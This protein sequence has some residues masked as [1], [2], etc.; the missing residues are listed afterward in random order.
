VP[1]RS[2]STKSNNEDAAARQA[3]R[4]KLWGDM[5]ILLAGVAAVVAIVWIISGHSVG[6]AGE[7]IWPMNITPGGQYVPFV[8]AAALLIAVAGWL[9]RPGRWEKTRRKVRVIWLIIIILISGLLAD[10]LLLMRSN[11]LLVVSGIITSREATSYFPA[12]IAIP[13]LPEALRDYPALMHKLPQH[14]RTHP[15]GPIVF[16]WVVDRWVQSSPALQH[17][18]AV[19][20]KRIDPLLTDDLPNILGRELGI[21]MTLADAHAAILS[22]FILVFLGSCTI[23]PLY[24]VG[25]TLFNST[26]ALRACLLFSTVPAFLLFGPTID[27]VVLLLAVLMLWVFILLCRSGN[28]LIGFIFAIA[29]LMSLGSAAVI[30]F[31]GLWW[32]FDRKTAS[33]QKAPPK[34]LLFGI[35]GALAL[36][37]VTFVILKLTL[38]LDFIAVLREGLAIHRNITTVEAGR[39]YWKW[40]LFDPLE[41]AFFLGGAAC[42][43]ALAG[44]R[45]GFAWAWL[46]AFVLL[47]A[48]G[49]VRGEVGRIWLF[50]MPPAIL[51]GA[52]RIDRLGKRFDLGF[53]SA[54][55]LQIGQAAS[56][57]VALDLFIVK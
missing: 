28:P 7:W 14:A 57:K 54:M 12:A 55:V 33:D 37:L 19:T 17:A 49:W 30:L 24:L 44:L 39:T 32:L 47:D 48:S 20:F 9:T 29:L 34:K 18:L 38:G 10:G 42:I 56:M 4:A 15:P 35:G 31:I 51:I 53:F 50:L 6:L 13:N 5:L 40:V 21:P 41:F 22:A 25:R 11:P 8:I 52:A 3:K 36:F 16:F 1:E 26:T 2:R 23:I 27:E 45:G 43:W 46:A